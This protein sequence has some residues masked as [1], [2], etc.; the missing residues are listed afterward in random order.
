M[1]KRNVPRR[2]GE[3]KPPDD[4]PSLAEQLRQVAPL[5]F[6]VKADV[7]RMQALWNRHAPALRKYLEQCEIPKPQS[8]ANGMRTGWEPAYGIYCWFSAVELALSGAAALLQQGIEHY[9]LDDL[10]GDPEAEAWLR[11]QLEG[12]DDKGA[13]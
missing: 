10:G 3:G 2:P 13:A 8:R 4:G 5:I 7:E 12:L 9:T 1:G 11:H 6:A